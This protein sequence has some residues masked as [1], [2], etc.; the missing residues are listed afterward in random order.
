[1]DRTFVYPGELP[2]VEDFMGFEKQAYYGMGGLIRS[3][4]GPNAGISNG[5]FQISATGPASMS[6][7]IG[8]GAIYQSQTVDSSAFGVLGTDSNTI[9]KQGLLVTPVTLAITA[10]STSGFSQ[11][12]LVQV[13][14]NEVD[15]G[16]VVPPFL[17]SANPSVPWNGANNLGAALNTIR[18]DQAVV[19]LVAGTAASTGSQIIPSPSAGS[20]PLWVILVSN[21]TTT[22]TSAN[23]SQST[24]APLFPNLESLGNSFIPSNYRVFTSSGTFTVPS[25][26]GK[27][28]VRVWGAGGGGGGVL[29]TGTYSAAGGA[30]GGGY[31]E[32]YVAVTPGQ[33]IAVTV[34]VGG[35]G[36]TGTPSNG[37]VGGT[38][39]FGSFMSATGGAGGN[40]AGN[41][42][43]A[44]SQGTGGTGTGGGLAVTGFAGNGG[45]AAT[46][47]GGGSGGGAFCSGTS[48][49]NAINGSGSIGSF[50]GGGGEGTAASSAGGFA[51][52]AGG[53]G[54]IVVN[55]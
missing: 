50:P 18:Q 30:A 54:L 49:G 40:L 42:V 29:S 7:I 32:G 8:T 15:N 37:G 14:F 4:I 26:I 36:G 48:Q 39:S 16:A 24:G 1:V 51:G 19:S 34:G 43:I 21:S 12:Y 3:A 9:M 13:G 38:S 55:Y 28:Y 52:G 6:V 35:T 11:Y 41:G 46:N 33:S 47:G 53:A 27:V 10:P 17:N 20:I 5:D 44:G 22:I 45:L 23:W 2:R 31:T 25:G